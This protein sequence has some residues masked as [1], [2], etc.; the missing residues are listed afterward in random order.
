MRSREPAVSENWYARPVFAVRDAPKALQFYTSKLGFKEDWRHEEDGRPRIVQVRR[1]G[2]ELILA[3]QW[4]GEAGRGLMFIS[5]DAAEFTS[6]KEAWAAR[7]VDLVVKI[8]RS[9]PARRGPPEERP[10]ARSRGRNQH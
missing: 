8:R 5:L 9:S 4:P 6:T 10:N 2:C 7:E 1:Q 3:D